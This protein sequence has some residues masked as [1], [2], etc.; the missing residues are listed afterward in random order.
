MKL[1]EKKKKFIVNR[2][3]VRR[4]GIEA[5]HST[6]RQSEYFSKYFET[7]DRLSNFLFEGINKKIGWF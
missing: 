5:N 4:S 2:P 7:E 6:V 3:T 1:Y